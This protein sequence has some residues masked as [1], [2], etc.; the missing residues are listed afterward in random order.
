MPLRTRW[1]R[2]A[3]GGLQG[4]GLELV[5]CLS[6]TSGGLLRM[7]STGW[8]SSPL[9]V[10]V[11]SASSSCLGRVWKCSPPPCPGIGSP[12]REAGSPSAL[13]VSTCPGIGGHSILLPSG[14]G[15]M[16]ALRQHS[17]RPPIERLFGG[18]S[19]PSCP[20]LVRSS[21]IRKSR[22]LGQARAR[23]L[24]EMIARAGSSRKGDLPGLSTNC[25]T[26]ARRGQR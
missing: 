15:T 14:A 10:R 7:P 4:S 8:R 23:P 2:V 9:P 26:G 22:M 18:G 1:S 21:A 19:P 12:E 13:T 11:L 3:R 25:S 6:R 17:C 16:P 24:P 20:A 5:V